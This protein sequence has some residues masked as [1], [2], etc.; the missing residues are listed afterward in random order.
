MFKCFFIF[1]L[2]YTL[3]WALARTENG[4]T[5]LHLAGIRGFTSVTKLLLEHGADPNVRTT[6]EMV[7]PKGCTHLKYSLY[8]I[9]GFAPPIFL[10]DRLGCFF[11]FFFWFD[12]PK[13]SIVFLCV[14][15]CEQGLRMHP[16]SWNI[17]GG[18]VDNAALLLEYG[19]DVNADFDSMKKEDGA[20]TSLDIVLQL[21][22]NEQGDERFVQLEKLLRQHGAKTMAELRQLPQNE[23]NQNPEAIGGNSGGT[24]L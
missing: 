22:D 7:R 3:A 10:K 9:L 20:V 14:C 1:L 11:F 18:H 16:L 23:Q 17:Y 24:E 15:L 19:A 2:R 4:E 12:H 13:Q 21:Q 8:C 6:Y 5:C